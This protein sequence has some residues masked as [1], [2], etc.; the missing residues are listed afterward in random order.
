MSPCYMPILKL[1]KSHLAHL[2]SIDSTHIFWSLHFWF[3]LFGY[4]HS[5]LIHW[6]I[7]TDSQLISQL[8]RLY[9]TGTAIIVPFHFD[10]CFFV[11]KISNPLLPTHL[12]M[13]SDIIID[14]SISMY[15]LAK[16]SGVVLLYIYSLLLLLS[17]KLWSQFR[18]SVSYKWLQIP[19]SLIIEKVH[20]APVTKFPNP[21]TPTPTPKKKEGATRKK[22]STL[23]WKR[24]MLE[25]LFINFLHGWAGLPNKPSYRSKFS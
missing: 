25:Y 5:I 4:S 19:Y 18:Y 10:C 13:L 24:T 12:N 11:I 6:H 22:F 9:D 3:Y 7:E 8:S 21:K 16:V 14:F 20:K 1:S 15:A 17:E 2:S 23:W